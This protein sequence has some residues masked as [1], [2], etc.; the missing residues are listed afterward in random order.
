MVI[1]G[2]YGTQKFNFNCTLKKM[3]FFQRTNVVLTDLLS[4]L[5][6]PI[7]IPCYFDQNLNTSIL[8]SNNMGC[9]WEQWKLTT[10]YGRHTLKVITYQKEKKERNRVNNW[11]EF[12]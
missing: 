6:A 11:I 10:L 9:Q 7:E 1:V 8:A 4:D 5:C 3:D 2:W 12:I